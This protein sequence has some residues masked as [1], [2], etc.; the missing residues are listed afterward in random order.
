MQRE[1]ANL[2]RLERNRLYM[3]TWFGSVSRLPNDDSQ[4]GITTYFSPLRDGLKPGD[5][6]NPGLDLLPDQAKSIVLAVGLLPFLQIGQIYLDSRYIGMPEYCR[7]TL[8]PLSWSPSSHGS[9]F[10]L[11]GSRFRAATGSG[12]DVSRSLY[13]A[14]TGGS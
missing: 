6:V 11:V 13:P 3:L 10:P 1:I 8:L 9:I 7:Q 4:F 5:P 2:E 14:L 12:R